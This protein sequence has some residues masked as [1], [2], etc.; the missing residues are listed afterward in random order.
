MSE[1][2]SKSQTL[3]GEA[4]ASVH[5]YLE[6]K[7]AGFQHGEIRKRLLKLWKAAEK[8]QGKSEL[9]ELL[10]TSSVVA[11]EYLE[12]RAERIWPSLGLGPLF[13]NGLLE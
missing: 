8:G 3:M 6:R 5:L 11:I 13:Q 10:S 2:K 7:D 4:E 9:I 12:Q 1:Q